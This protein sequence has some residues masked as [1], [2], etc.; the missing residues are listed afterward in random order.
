MATTPN[1]ISDLP[2]ASSANNTDLM[3]VDQ[4]AGGGT[5]VTRSLA[6]SLLAPLIAKLI[7]PL[8]PAGGPTW[9]S[10]SGA[11]TATNVVVGSLYSDTNGPVGSTLYVF[12]SDNAW[13][14]AG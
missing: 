5:Y 8:P 11:P 4:S 10:G 6:L 3:A 14:V 12:E 2:A 13:H 1:Q 7:S 9:T